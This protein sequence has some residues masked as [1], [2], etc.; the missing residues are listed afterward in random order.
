MRWNYKV[1]D[2]WC[3]RLGGAGSNG[4]NSYIS[5][6]W[7]FADILRYSLC[8]ILYS[9]LELVSSLQRSVGTVALVN[10]LTDGKWAVLRIILRGVGHNISYISCPVRFSA[11]SQAE[12]GSSLWWRLTLTVNTALW[13]LK[14]Q[15]EVDS[16]LWWRLTLIDNTAIRDLTTHKQW[17][18]FS[19]R[20]WKE[21]ARSYPQLI[22]VLY[23]PMTKTLSKLSF[24]LKRSASKELMQEPS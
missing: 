1:L 3:S 24:T 6:C 5:R 11:L 15:A 22:Y 4:R 12:V 9:Q 8:Y 20:V 18:S 17:H 14:T 2:F 10:L 13:G 21:V 16:S 23:I 7:S 19:L